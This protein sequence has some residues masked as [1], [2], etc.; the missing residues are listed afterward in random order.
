MA[1][2]LV[3]AKAHW[4]DSLSQ[5]EVDKLPPYKRQTYNARSQIGD[6]IVV[7]PNGWKWGREE[8]LPNYVVVKIPNLKVE[9]AKEY[10]Y[11]LF[12]KIGVNEAGDPVAPVLKGRKHQIPKAVIDNAKQLSKST[13][14][15]DA[16]QKD[17]F[18]AGIIKKV[19]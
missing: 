14:V 9:D 6:V 17:S 2:L 16:A 18:I 4:M 3:K 15:V 11:P 1:E 7:K 10:E 5:E 13:I 8:C 12:G 19:K